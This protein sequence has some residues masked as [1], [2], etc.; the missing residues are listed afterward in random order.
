MMMKNEAESRDSV[1]E[2]LRGFYVPC[3]LHTTDGWRQSHDA[4]KDPST[5]STWI[6]RKRGTSWIVISHKWLTEREVSTT[7][8]RGGTSKCVVETGSL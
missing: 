5:N 3:A 4:G 2:F 1:V 8:I 7:A 6:L